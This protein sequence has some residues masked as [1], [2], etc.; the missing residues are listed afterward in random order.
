MPGTMIAI[1][2]FSS[3]KAPLESHLLLSYKWKQYSYFSVL[4]Q[5]ISRDNN[6]EFTFWIQ[7]NW[8]RSL[9][10]RCNVILINLS[11]FLLVMTFSEIF[12]LACEHCTVIS[13][14]SAFCLLLHIS[15]LLQV[16]FPQ[17]CLPVGYLVLACFGD[18][19]T[20]QQI[21]AF[22]IRRMH[23][24][25]VVAFTLHSITLCRC[26]AAPDKNYTCFCLY[27]SK[28]CSCV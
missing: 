8:M 10:K 9:A 1:H 22:L 26:S 24:L 4:V 23:S 25:C 14:D 27:K 11:K 17:L 15:S 16:V 5:L 28:L 13:V 18:D 20:P 2:L 3:D 6:N 7:H 12:V 19:W 21:S